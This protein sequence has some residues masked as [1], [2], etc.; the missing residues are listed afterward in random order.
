MNNEN[1]PPPVDL[2][3][4]SSSNDVLSDSRSFDPSSHIDHHQLKIIKSTVINSQPQDFVVTNG[5]TYRINRSPIGISMRGRKSTLCDSTASSAS[6]GPNETPEHAKIR[7]LLKAL[8]D[9][10]R[11]I[12]EQSE[13]LVSLRQNEKTYRNRINSLEIKC[14]DPVTIFP[15]TVVAASRNLTEEVKLNDSTSRHRNKFKTALRNEKDL[16]IR[17]FSPALSQLNPFGDEQGASKLRSFSEDSSHSSCT[18]P[19]SNQSTP[20]NGVTGAKNMP[21]SSHDAP[22][23]ARSSVDDVIDH[24]PIK[25]DADIHIENM[26]LIENALNKNKKTIP[27]KKSAL[28]ARLGMSTKDRRSEEKESSRSVNQTGIRKLKSSPLLATT[29]I[30]DDSEQSP[31]IWQRSGMNSSATSCTLFIAHDNPQLGKTVADSVGNGM[32]LMIESKSCDDRI[33]FVLAN[34]VFS[35]SVEKVLIS[36]GTATSAASKTLPRGSQCL[37]CRDIRAF[38]FNLKDCETRVQGVIAEINL[39]QENLPL[40]CTVD[41]SDEEKLMAFFRSCDARVDV[42]LAPHHTQTWYPYWEYSSVPNA[43]VA[44]G[45][46]PGIGSRKMAPQFRSKG[47]G[48]LR[49]GDDMSRFGTSFLS[50]D[51]FETFMDE[52]KGGVENK[53][54]PKKSQSEPVVVNG[55][56]PSDNKSIN[57]PTMRSHENI[58]KGGIA[59]IQDLKDTLETLQSSALKWSDRV[60][61]LQNFSDYLS[62]NIDTMKNEGK[63][64]HSIVD[65]IALCLCGQLSN[66][67]NPLVLKEATRCAGLVGS[68]CALLNVNAP[69]AVSLANNWTSLFILC[70]HNLRHANK[71]VSDT[72]KS[73]VSSLIG[74]S[75]V[76][77]RTLAMNIKDIIAGPLRSG[78]TN[79][80][81][82]NAPNTARVLQW[83]IAIVEDYSNRICSS[84]SY[85]E[86]VSVVHF[87]DNLDNFPLGYK[88]LEH[89]SNSLILIAQSTT[90]LLNHKDVAVRE[91]ALTLCAQLLSL[92]VLH[93]GKVSMFN[94]HSYHNHNYDV[95]QVS[96]SVELK[97]VIPFPKDLESMMNSLSEDCRN[98]V[99]STLEPKILSKVVQ[100]SIEYSN[101]LY[102]VSK[103]QVNGPEPCQE[104]TSPRSN[105]APPTRDYKK[106]LSSLSGPKH[107]RQRKIRRSSSDMSNTSNGTSPDTKADSLADMLFEVN[108]SLKVPPKDSD[109]WERLTTVRCS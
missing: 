25:T 47:I 82:P 105:C 11:Q 20:S 104:M 93:S 22:S 91:A 12:A 33:A 89:E 49:L 43:T 32:E 78:A 7:M 106:S 18:P 102:S 15:D 63:L 108:L 10:N 88:Y 109:S 24:S 28:A 35:G 99:S 27:S 3:R 66:Q 37:I 98:I 75:I 71:G 87:S 53:I 42:I 70:V 50:C 92:D 30:I 68:H 34:I 76:N 17:T 54:A 56:P 61:C 85:A 26:Q 51:G 72:A 6:P 29:T 77:L 46:Q 100:R 4:S 67:K 84:I 45:P 40:G 60:V 48:Y 1:F 21:L 41:V 62:G 55:Y 52:G 95:S 36:N 74:S 16:K 31:F 97:K 94:L 8:D 79:Q 9:A 44:S 96:V 83:I 19:L 86:D 107:R 69:D 5:Q 73:A 58:S 59:N 64:Q 57:H 65:N 2:L 39:C 13:E 14:G 23:P 90:P 38:A 101:K 81:M 80:L 103:N